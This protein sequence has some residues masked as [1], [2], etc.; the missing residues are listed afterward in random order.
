M[1]TAALVLT[2][3]LALPAAAEDASR[4]CA[5]LR[6]EAALVSADGKDWPGLN[7]YRDANMKLAP[8]GA[9]RGG[10]FGDSITQ[11]WNLAESFPG[12][13]YVDRGIAGQTTPQMRLRF[14]EDVIAL[15]PA[16]VVIL[17][18]TNDIAGNTG[19]ETL[20]T[21]EGN[22]AEL[23]AL[24]DGAGITV[25][26]ASVLP[27]ARYPWKPSVQPVAE[28]L[29]LNAWIKDYAQNHGHV[30][31][32]YYSA[33]I[34]ADGGMNPYLTADGVHP[35]AVGYEVMTPLARDALARAR[36]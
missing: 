24:A 36:R 13:P 32:D 10:F 31:L 34:G 14:C 9:G 6:G 30:Y 19:P 1:R 4:A 33:M 26:M 8:A 3:A 28:I 2:F 27:V 5:A 35:N 25:V 15:K 29:A 20:E 16:A 17:A 22:L 21:I 11:Y 12:R 23:A 7:R 18:G